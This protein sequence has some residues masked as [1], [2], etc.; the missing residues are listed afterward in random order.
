MLGLGLGPVLISV[1]NL[2]REKGHELAIDA[3][4][5]IPDAIL[6]VVGEGPL[7]RTLH[8]RAERIGIADRVRFLSA[9]PQADLATVYSAADALILASSR[10]GWPNVLLEA[11]ACGTPVVATQVGGVRE[12][13]CD[14]DAGILVKERRSAAIAT[15]V[16]DLLAHPPRRADTRRHAQKYEWRET[17]CGQAELFANVVSTSMHH[18]LKLLPD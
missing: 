1:G 17:A 2:V 14:P 7:Q 8:A 9:R 11:M 10:E 4:A 12:I 3:I 15:A 16:R 5:Q 6:L 13:V 18:A